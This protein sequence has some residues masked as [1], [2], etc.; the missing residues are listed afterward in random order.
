VGL[1]LWLQVVISIFLLFPFVSTPAQAHVTVP[2]GRPCGEGRA[3]QTCGPE[4]ST[5]AT[6]VTVDGAAAAYCHYNACADDGS[7][8]DGTVCSTVHGTQGDYQACYPGEEE[9]PVMTSHT[10]EA[11]LE[12]IFAINIPTVQISDVVISEGGGE[13]HVDIPW[14]ADYIIGVYRYAVFVGSI[15]AAVMIMIG[16]IQWLTA[17][18]NASRI[19]SAKTRITDATTGLILLVGSFLILVTI[20]PDLVAMRP[21]RITSVEPDIFEGAARSLPGEELGEANDPVA[22]EGVIAGAREAGVDPCLMLTLCRKESGLRMGAYNGMSRNRPI[23]D[24]IAFGPCQVLARN[25]NPSTSTGRRFNDIVREH[26]PDLPITEGWPRRVSSD[27]DI[28]QRVAIGRWLMTNNAGSGFVG[29]TLFSGSMSF[30]RGNALCAVAAYGSGPAAI[31]RWQQANNCTPQPDSMEEAHEHGLSTALER[32]C[33]PEWPAIGSGGTSI[34]E[35]DGFQCGS[36]ERNSAAEWEGACA[37]TGERCFTV[38]GT[39]AASSIFR[40]YEG[41]T[42]NHPECVE[43]QD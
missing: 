7:C 36:P 25:L 38:R 16:G 24:A 37:S 1:Q 33:I 12:P 4:T 10:A 34:C 40:M 27:D 29:A 28:A 15:L 31:R 11:D 5:G 21:L 2:V 42:R 8:P 17:G 19:G 18:G 41:I 13:R 39:G 3:G 22:V 14:L 6:C 43:G 26:Y 20:S 23:E 32:A 9:E 35:S 30:C